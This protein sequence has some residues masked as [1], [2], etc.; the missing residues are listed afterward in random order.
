MHIVFTYPVKSESKGWYFVDDNDELPPCQP[1]ILN[2]KYLSE[3]YFESDSDFSGKCSVPVLYDMDSNK[4]INNNSNDIIKMFNE[5][6]PLFNYLPVNLFPQ[7]L[8]MNNFIHLLSTYIFK[9][10]MTKDQE[11]YNDNA[12]LCYYSLDT[13]NMVLAT[14]PYINGSLLT[15]SDIKLFSLIARY[16]TG[17][18]TVFKLNWKY[19]RTDYPSIL[20][21]AK[22]MYLLVGESVNINHIKLGIYSKEMGWN[23]DGIIPLG[24]GFEWEEKEICKMKNKKKLTYYNYWEDQKYKIVLILMLVVLL[25]IV[26]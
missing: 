14:T 15:E 1:D 5:L 10:G 3:Y 19:I 2:H 22:R 16:D 4:I 13:L 6:N 20:N 11:E 7:I 17:Y 12:S 21:W 9:A 23:K 18:A 26:K 25:I 24:R 8:Q